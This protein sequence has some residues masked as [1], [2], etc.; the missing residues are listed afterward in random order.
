M[1]VDN[2]YKNYLKKAKH[3]KHLIFLIQLIII[4]SFISFWELFSF[5]HIINPFIFSAP[6]K[7]IK[8]IY[9]LIINYHLFK[10]I[11]V[12]LFE[13]LLSF[14]LGTGFGLL[15]ATIMYL[16]PIL[17]KIINPFLT[18]INSLPKVA[19]GPMIIIWF[20]ANHNSIIIMALLINLIINIINIYNG[21]SNIDSNKLFLLKTFKATKWQI[22]KYLVFRESYNS[23]IASLKINIS[24]TLIGVIMGE[25]LVSSSGI[26]YLIIYGTQIFNLNIVISCIII[27]IIISTLL[28]CLINVIEKNKKPN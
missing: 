27:L 22:L 23:I 1:N 8:S 24:M 14:I 7:I 6:S 17:A 11:I 5:Y 28:Y 21:F 25:F 15:I 2:L 13:T 19:L 3:E 4:I 20:G 16:I 26:G 12:T 18:M 9:S 10:H